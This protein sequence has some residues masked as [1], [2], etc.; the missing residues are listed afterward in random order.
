MNQNKWWA[1]RLCFPVGAQHAAPLQVAESR[2][3]RLGFDLVFTT[4]LSLA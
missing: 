4:K 2:M 3:Y 1:I